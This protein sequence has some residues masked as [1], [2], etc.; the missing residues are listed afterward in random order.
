MRRRGLY[1]GS[2]GNGITAP[3]PE[4]AAGEKTGVEGTDS[5]EGHAPQLQ[6]NGVTFTKICRLTGKQYVPG[7]A[8]HGSGLF[9]LL[10]IRLTL[11][12]T[13]NAHGVSFLHSKQRVII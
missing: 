10:M 12:Y 6:G 11:P 9:Y 5:T 7:P 3:R 2:T 8:A 1:P 13:A 4:H